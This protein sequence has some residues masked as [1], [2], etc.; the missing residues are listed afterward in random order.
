MNLIGGFREANARDVLL[1]VLEVQLALRPDHMITLELLPGLIELYDREDKFVCVLLNR[2]L[3][4]CIQDCAD[5]LRPR[6][7]FFKGF[8]SP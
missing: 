4:I 2:L 5:S 7:F 8:T 6:V 1:V 3:W